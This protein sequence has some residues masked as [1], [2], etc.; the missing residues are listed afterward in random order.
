M[1]AIHTAGIC[2]LV[3]AGAALAASSAITV[4]SDGFG[5]ISETRTLELEKGRQSWLF[6]GVSR[7][8]QPSSV[9]F[10]CDG[11]QL[12][13]QNFEYDLV[14]DRALLARYLGQEIEVQQEGG[15]WVTGT[16]LSA[17]GGLVL[18]TDFGVTSMRLNAVQ[19][20]RFPSLPDGLRIRPALRWELESRRGG[21][22]EATVSYLSGGLGWKAEYVCLLNEQD[23]G[24]DMASWVNLSN[25]TGLNWEGAT[26]QL[27]AGEVNRQ[28]SPRYNKRGPEMLDA[29][30]VADG[31]FQEESFFEYHLYTLGRPVDLAHNQDKQVPLFDPVDVTIDKRYRVDSG[32]MH[33]GVQVKLAFIN[34]KGKGPGLALPAGTVRLYKLDSRGGRQLIGED[35]IK[36]TPVDEE[37]E[38][39]AGKAFDLVA[40]RVVLEEKRSGRVV[41]REVEFVLKNRKPKEAV[42]I[43]VHERLWGDWKVISCS[44]EY[45]QKD[46]YTLELPVQVPAGKEITV[47]LRVRHQS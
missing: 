22:R 36:H 24:M 28:Q 40:E 33:D 6:E 46:A 29:A 13:E 12:L 38:L 2:S 18:Q 37:I 32:R 30:M 26:L 39:T 34:S 42:E 8:I 3:L 44:G 35:G 4:Y 5:L 47:R 43:L 1:R 15:A 45:R 20:T 19:A 23:D 41:E 14:D 10:D 21:S 17:D 9:L 25:R 11:V 16:L 27:V 7:Q 31:G